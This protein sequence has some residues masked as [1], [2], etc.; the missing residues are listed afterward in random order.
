MKRSEMINILQ[1]LLEKSESIDIPKELAKEV[2]AE[3]EKAGM[4]PP[5]HKL[6]HLKTVDYS[7]ETE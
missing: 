3:V 1:E 6:K 2:L 7:W 5:K 4:L